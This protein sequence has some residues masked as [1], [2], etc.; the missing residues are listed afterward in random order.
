M[1]DSN[2]TLKSRLFI[3]FYKAFQMT[4]NKR[5]QYDN[6]SHDLTNNKSKKKKKSCMYLFN[7]Y[8]C[9]FMAELICF[10][11]LCEL[12]ADM[13]MICLYVPINIC[14]MKKQTN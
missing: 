10:D 9:V 13:S 5:F 1:C 3:I 2:R 12:R 6:H 11:H 4:Q 8:V 14:W 7:I